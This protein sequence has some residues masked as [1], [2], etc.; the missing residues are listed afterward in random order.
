MSRRQHKLRQFLSGDKK[1]G[2]LTSSPET[3]ESQERTV[4]LPRTPTLS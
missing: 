1:R 4:L 2:Q 3:D